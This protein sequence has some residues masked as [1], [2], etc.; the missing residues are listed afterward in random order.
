MA[1]TSFVTLSVNGFKR[2]FEITHAERLLGMRNNG[3]W[4]LDDNRYEL[5]SNGTL[6][7]RS[8]KKSSGK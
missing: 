2:E 3:G 8:S 7:K 1:K 6:F 5:S 4:V